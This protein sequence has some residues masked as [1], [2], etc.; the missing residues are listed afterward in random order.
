MREGSG[1]SSVNAVKTWKVIYPAEFSDQP[2]KFLKSIP[3]ATI[4][5]IL[6]IW[7]LSCF[8]VSRSLIVTV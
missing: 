1:V 5:L 6:E 2:N 4:S 3:S 8:K 7:I